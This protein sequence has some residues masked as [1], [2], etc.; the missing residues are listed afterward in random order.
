MSHIAGVGKRGHHMLGGKI[1][2]N[3]MYNMWEKCEWETRGMG[4]KDC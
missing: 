2:W 1:E 3:N 4:S